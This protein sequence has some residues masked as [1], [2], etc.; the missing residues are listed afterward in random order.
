MTYT[1]KIATFIVINS[2]LWVWCSYILAFMGMLSIAESLSSQVVTVLLG[3]TIGY[4][5]KAL[6]ENINKNRQEKPTNDYADS[7]KLDFIE[8]VIDNPQEM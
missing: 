8:E 5:V 1:K 2:V 7:Y 4:L 3:T 6:I